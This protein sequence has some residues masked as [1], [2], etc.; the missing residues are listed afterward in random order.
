MLVM[1][2]FTIMHSVQNNSDQISPYDKQIKRTRS[3]I[4]FGTVMAGIFLFPAAASQLFGII[5]MFVL[6]LTIANFGLLLIMLEPVTQ[7]ARI[8]HLVFIAYIVV[9]AATVGIGILAISYS[10]FTGKPEAFNDNFYLLIL[11]L[12]VGVL[13]TFTSVIL[14]QYRY[15][16]A[17][18]AAQSIKVIVA[19]EIASLR[20]NLSSSPTERQATEPSPQAPK[21]Q[22]PYRNAAIATDIEK[23]SSPTLTSPL[24]SNPP[25]PQSNRVL[26]PAPQP[27]PEPPSD[28]PKP[29]S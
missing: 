17:Y 2:S 23:S 26:P 21:V 20:T 12:L 4:L 8:N 14:Y 5:G 16:P 6:F 11:A 7:R 10:Y 15:L 13:H 27:T 29:Q 24:G 18:V 9:G 1:L 19:P 22:N 3:A 25:P 28:T